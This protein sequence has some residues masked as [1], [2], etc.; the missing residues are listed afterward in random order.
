[1]ALPKPRLPRPR[2]RW[3]AVLALLAA[4]AVVVV[5]VVS[6]KKPAD[7]GTAA[8]TTATGAATV[9]RRNL[10][11]TDTESGTLSYANSQTVY[12]R[13]SGTITWVPQVGQVIHPGHT[14]FEVDNKPVLLMN[15]STPAYRALT[16]SDISGPDVYEL[17]KNLV[18][19]G[20][21]PDGIVVDDEWQAATTAGIERM[22]YDL[23]QTETGALTLG[24]VVFLPGPQMIQTVD[25]TVGSTAAS[26]SPPQSSSNA[27]FVDYPSDSSTTST[28]TTTTSTDTTDT[29]TATTNTTSGT[30]TTTTG[31]GTIPTSTGTSTTTTTTPKT[32]TTPRSSTTVSGGDNLSKR[33]LQALMRLIAQ[34]QRE[35]RAEQRASHS[36]SSSSGKPSSKSPTT[37]SPS[38]KSS[39]SKTG[40]TGASGESGT[41]GGGSATAVL[42]TSSTKLVV[43]VDLS[44]SSQS[45][46]TIGE[47]VSV[48][49]PNGSTV[50]GHV[51]AVSPVATSSSS[52]DSGSGGGGNSGGSGGSLSGSGSGSST[53]PV[54]VDAR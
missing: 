43:T 42:S 52:A 28:D 26:Y 32:P 9:Q 20:Y 30:A 18:D 31:T 39:S 11:A 4:A 6:N 3:I 50:G 49:M 19:L 13:L 7:S 8:G 10:V 54:T 12:N 16:S 33:T 27:L 25:T 41:G 34:Q 45:E 44:A 51:T 46:A 2:G 1:M 35:L 23:G 47:K 24:Q 48:E 36:P 5:V 37:K 17:N 21:D 29:G 38:S 53:V 14:L 40:D 15:G 22:Q